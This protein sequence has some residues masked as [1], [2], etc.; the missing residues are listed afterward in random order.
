M[1]TAVHRRSGGPD[2]VRVVQVAQPSVGPDEVLVRV[3]ASTVSA[4]DTGR[5]RGNVV[6]RIATD[7]AAPAT[8]TPEHTR[9]AAS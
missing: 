8:S 1:R 3:H 6:L 7:P 5:T 2:T 4:V 9:E